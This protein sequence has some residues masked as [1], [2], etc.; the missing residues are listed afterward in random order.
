MKNPDEPGYRE[1]IDMKLSAFEKNAEERNRQ[2]AEIDF[3]KT[4]EKA[5]TDIDGVSE[6]KKDCSNEQSM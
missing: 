2:A 5:Q 3:S 6:K 1:K 4:A